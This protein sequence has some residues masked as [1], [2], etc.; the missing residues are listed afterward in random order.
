MFFAGITMQD[1][2]HKNKKIT[3]HE[4]REYIMTQGVGRDAPRYFCK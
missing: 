2:F 4:E 1:N 3:Q